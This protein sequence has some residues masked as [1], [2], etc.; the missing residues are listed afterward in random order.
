[1][2]VTPEP[3]PE[4]AGLKWEQLIGMEGSAGQL[5]ESPEDIQRHLV[6]IRIVAEEFDRPLE[7]VALFYLEEL[8]RLRPRATIADF[9]PVLVSKK[10]RE[11]Y[12]SARSPPGGRPD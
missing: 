6:S 11:H 12:R 10:I 8:A 1:M 3:Q 2:N 9:L 7:E 5:R 4:Q